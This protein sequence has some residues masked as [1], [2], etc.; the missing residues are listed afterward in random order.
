MKITEVTIRFN[1]VLVDFD[2]P[3]NMELKFQLPPDNVQEAYRM[4]KNAVRECLI[5]E[6]ANPDTT[7]FEGTYE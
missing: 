3:F 2:V 5:Q 1:S 4:A 6:G 7:I